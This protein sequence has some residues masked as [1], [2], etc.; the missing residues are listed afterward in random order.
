MHRRFL[1][2]ACAGLLVA[3][4]AAAQ[5]PGTASGSGTI[6]RER[7][8]P[9]RPGQT[10]TLEHLGYS[11]EAQNRRIARLGLMVSAQPNYLRVLGDA[12]AERGLGPDRA[13]AINRPARATKRAAGQAGAG[14]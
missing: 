4:V 7:D 10:V 6:D 14:G 2:L 1:A 9:A 5:Q 11:T 8:D 3:G 13:S 12:Y